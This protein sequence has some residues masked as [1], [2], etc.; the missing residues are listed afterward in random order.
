VFAASSGFAKGVQWAVSHMPI[1]AIVVFPPKHLSLELSRGIYRKF[2]TY[3]N[4]TD[5][6]DQWVEAETLRR[7]EP[8]EAYLIV[9]YISVYICFQEL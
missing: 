1:L 5:D 3:E 4:W 7:Y 8:P 6:Y 9:E 2:L